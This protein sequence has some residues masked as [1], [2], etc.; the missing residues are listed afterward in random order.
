MLS[1]K[2]KKPRPDA[3]L[4][5]Q[6]KRNPKR[7]LTGSGQKILTRRRRRRE[8]NIISEIKRR[9]GFKVRVVSSVSNAEE[10]PR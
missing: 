4:E 7:R 3:E 1:V 2:I 8:Y 9:K 6:S 10:R 5:G